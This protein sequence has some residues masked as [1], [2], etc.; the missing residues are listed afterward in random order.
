MFHSDVES[1]FQVRGPATVNALES[2]VDETPG[3]SYCLVSAEHR[4]TLPGNVESGMT[5]C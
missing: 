4:C 3:I 1:Q 5:A 2:N